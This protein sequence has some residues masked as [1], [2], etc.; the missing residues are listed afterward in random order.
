MTKEQI[1]EGP[2]PMFQSSTF[3]FGRVK[4]GSRI[5][6][7]YNYTNTGKSSF[8]C[9]KVD[10]E[11]NIK[12][13]LT[14]ETRAGGKGKISMTLDTSLMSKGDQLLRITLTTNSP[15]RPVINLYIAGIIE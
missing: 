14:P 8:V 4:A 13:I 5:D 1:A 9:H 6:V 10:T 3:S 7:V 15:S 12:E 2:M 11:G